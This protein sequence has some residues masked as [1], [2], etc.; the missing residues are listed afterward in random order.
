[1]RALNAASLHSS[2]IRAPACD[3]FKHLWHSSFFILSY[4]RVF[5]VIFFR[6]RGA[7]LNK[8]VN[9]PTK[10][11]LYLKCLFFNIFKFFLKLFSK[12]TLA[13]AP[14]RD[15]NLSSSLLLTVIPPGNSSSSSSSS[16]SS[17]YSS[18]RTGGSLSAS[19]SRVRI[20]IGE[21]QPQFCRLSP[22]R[23]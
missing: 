10:I 6:L 7:Q 17:M 14:L 13:R 20:C 19:V 9:K 21:T 5:E 1:M 2:Q 16:F 8:Y 18:S 3:I 11:F 4:Q 12:N 23:N 22:T 15:S